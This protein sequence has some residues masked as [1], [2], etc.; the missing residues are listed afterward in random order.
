MIDGGVAPRPPSRLPLLYFA[1]AHLCLAAALAALA[2]F[3]HSFYGFFY[4]PRM[5]AAVHLVTL[6]WITSHIVGALYMIAPMALRT[7]LVTNRADTFAFWSYAIGVTGMVAH[8]WIGELRGMVWGALL[9]LGTLL[10]IGVRVV[11]A[12]RGAPIHA[13]IKLHYWLAF[14][15]VAA[16]ATLGILLGLH[17]LRPFLRLEPLE[18]VFAH[19]HLAA[20]GWATM[21]VFGSA[22]RLLPMM[23]PSAPPPAASGWGSALLLETGVLGLVA[24]FLG[25]HDATW[26]FAAVAAASVAWFLGVVTWLL[27]HRRRAGPGLPRLD[28]TRLHV[29]QALVYLVATTVLG[30]ALAFAPRST[31]TLRLAKVY[32]VC[33]LL[34]FF[35]SMILGV[36]GRHVPVLIWTRAMLATGPP[37]RSP[38]RLRSPVLAAIELGAW[39]CGVPLLAFALWRESPPTLSFAGWLL[40]AAVA[41]SAVSQI[42]ALRS[43]AG[44]G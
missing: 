9:V 11:S 39:S 23:L 4:H 22:Y 16:A 42:G 3:P 6:G 14:V 35:G 28:L 41:A 40:L 38:Y 25:G 20:L 32:G 15:N 10:L 1:Y 37:A 43:A 7:R 5:L 44:G 26:L 27:R 21:T 2:A 12:L 30:L 29:V 18:G 36:A 19:A 17:R 31:D 34:G 33:G 8:F 24:G 13:G